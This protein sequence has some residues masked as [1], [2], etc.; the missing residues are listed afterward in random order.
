M[1]LDFPEGA[2]VQINIAPAGSGAMFRDPLL[3][4][5]AVAPSRRRHPFL[6]GAVVVV[7]VGVAFLAGQR[8]APAGRAVQLAHAQAYHLPPYQPPSIPEQTAEVP[9]AFRQQLQAPP[10]V[11]PPPG[12]AAPSVVPGEDGFGMAKEN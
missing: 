10:K 9:P 6:V 5:P 3:A 2:H 11:T 7:L 4:T 1:N 12:I 8:T